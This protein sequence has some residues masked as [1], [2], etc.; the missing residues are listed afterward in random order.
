MAIGI[1]GGCGYIKSKNYSDT[2]VTLAA[3][4]GGIDNWQSY[5]TAGANCYVY[6]LQFTDIPNSG[7]TINSDVTVIP[8]G[9]ITQSL[10]EKFNQINAVEVITNSSS[11]D[12]V[13]FYAFNGKPT[14]NIDVT[15]RVIFE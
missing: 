2:D 11:Q 13:R 4:T 12:V 1:I 6:D 7:I 8:R 14:D 9:T 5:S 15:L 10:I 3:Q